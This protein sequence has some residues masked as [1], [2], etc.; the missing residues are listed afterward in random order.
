MYFE[1]IYHSQKRSVICN[2]FICYN[3]ELGTLLT[4]HLRVIQG[5]QQSTFNTFI[6]FFG[7]SGFEHMTFYSSADFANH[8]YELMLK[9]QNDSQKMKFSNVTKNMS[10][11]CCRD[12]IHTNGIQKFWFFPPFLVTYFLIANE[13]KYSLLDWIDCYLTNKKTFF[14]DLQDMLWHKSKA[15]LRLVNTKSVIKKYLVSFV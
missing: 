1:L 8:Y 6:I 15:I 9:W 12:A 7:R 14:L 10:Y 3:W 11:T 4:C 5:T 13:W 2:L